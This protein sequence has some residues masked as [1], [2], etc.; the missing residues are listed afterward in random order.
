M[1]ADYFQIMNTAISHLEMLEEQSP[2]KK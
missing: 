2:R 1:I